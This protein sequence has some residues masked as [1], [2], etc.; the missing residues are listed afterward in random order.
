MTLHSISCKKQRGKVIRR[1]CELPAGM[2]VAYIEKSECALRVSITL[3]DGSL[4]NRLDFNPE[5]AQKGT[6]VSRFRLGVFA[7]AVRLAHHH[8]RHRRLLFQSLQSDVGCLDLLL[9]F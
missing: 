9:E 7:R 3:A 5:L 8:H 4:V 1:T 6:Q 2:S